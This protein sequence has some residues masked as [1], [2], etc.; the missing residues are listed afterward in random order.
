MLLVVDFSDLELEFDRTDIH[1][2]NSADFTVGKLL[3]KLCDGIEKLGN[4]IIA[5]KSMVNLLDP[6]RNCLDAARKVKDI[7]LNEWDTLYIVR[8]C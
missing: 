2:D 1:F 6:D 8:R 7:T 4:T 3:G 5:N